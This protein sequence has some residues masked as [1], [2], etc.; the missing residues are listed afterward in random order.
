MKEIMNMEKNM[1]LELS[2]GLMAQL[3]LANF[4]TIIFTEKEFILGLIIENMKENGKQIKC[5]GKAH[6]HGRMDVN[7]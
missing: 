6:L 2:N 7:I 3:I 4:I 5:M 1:E